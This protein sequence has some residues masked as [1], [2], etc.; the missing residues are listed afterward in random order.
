[1]RKLNIS[2][3][4]WDTVNKIDACDMLG[5]KKKTGNITRLDL[6]E[7]LLALGVS[8]GE[9]K[10]LSSKKDFIREEDIKS[11]VKSYMT[12]IAL[13]EFAKTNTENKI[14]NQDAV[15]AIADEYVQTGFGLIEE[16]FG[17]FSDY[18]EDDCIDR[19]IEKMD[20]MYADIIEEQ[21]EEQPI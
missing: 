17:D 20:E 9:K 5:L 12:S 15:F 7:F 13:S 1:M 11:Q 16:M 4:H 6:Y 3:E 2:S 8:S 18:N 14:S 10:T 21:S 19:M